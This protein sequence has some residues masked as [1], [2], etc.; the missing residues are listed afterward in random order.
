MM[1]NME[2]VQMPTLT[3]SEYK[4]DTCTVAAEN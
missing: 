2:V 4:E 1:E 3:E